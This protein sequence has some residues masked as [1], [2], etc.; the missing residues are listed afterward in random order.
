MARLRKNINC[1]E[2][3]SPN[4]KGKQF[5]SDTCAHINLL[6]RKKVKREA[7]KHLKP[8]YNG[9]SKIDEVAYYKDLISR[10]TTYSELRRLDTMKHKR[11]KGWI[12]KYCR[13]KWM[14]SAE[15]HMDKV[16][17]EKA[18]RAIARVSEV[19]KLSYIKRVIKSYSNLENDI[20][21]ECECINGHILKRKAI[22]LLKENECT[23]C[24]YANVRNKKRIKKELQLKAKINDTKGI[25]L[26][27]ELERVKIVS[28]FIDRGEYKNYSSW[29]SSP[30]SYEYAWLRNGKGRYYLT[31]ELKINIDRINYFI[32]KTTGARCPYP[33]KKGYIWCKHCET[34]KTNDNFRGKNICIE[35]SKVYRRENYYEAQ[36]IQGRINYNTNPIIKLSSLVRVYVNSA[37][38]GKPK[39]Y[40]TKDILG[41]EWNEFRDYI[42]GMFEPWMNWDNHGHGR[43]KWALQH[44]IPKAYAETEEDIYRLNYHKNLMPMNFSDNGA[45]SDRILR[46]Q[47]NEWHYDN[48]GDFLD[49]Y[50]DRILD[51]M[52]KIYLKS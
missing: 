6:K 30:I 20:K 5:C 21:V 33:K 26:K 38:K 40:R 39:S 19:S 14:L 48:C 46:Y 7:T 17:K 52:D 3:N 43:G 12:V 23:M 29:I 1:K 44:I 28:N 9:L 34:E 2:C 15:S 45:L 27:K 50:K 37:L 24:R 47:L 4:S 41:M 8:L 18:E 36:K 31:N 13:P 32:Y 25:K 49:K 10:V 35:C 11:S 16:Q 51:N 42:E 22:S